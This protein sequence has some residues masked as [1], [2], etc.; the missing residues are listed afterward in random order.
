MATRSQLTFGRWLD[1]GSPVFL[2]QDNDVRHTFRGN[3]ARS[4]R[5]TEC[6]S[7]TPPENASG[8]RRDRFRLQQLNIKTSSGDATGSIAAVRAKLDAVG[9]NIYDLGI[10]NG[11]IARATETVTKDGHVY[12][13]AGK[14]A[15]SDTVRAASADRVGRTVQ[16]SAGA[17]NGAAEV[18]GRVKTDVS[19]SA[20]VLANSLNTATP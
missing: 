20:A 10:N 19:R 17:P 11:S 16:S 15:G 9:G 14:I 5:K 13:S 8:R 6:A 18:S 2:D 3:A 12:L 7:S 1:V 4:P